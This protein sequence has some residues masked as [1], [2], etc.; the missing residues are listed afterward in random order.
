MLHLSVTRP[1]PL[2]WRNGS[3]LDGYFSWL[4]LVYFSEALVVSKLNI[5]KEVVFTT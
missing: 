1:T 5:S 3:D 2:R 4:V